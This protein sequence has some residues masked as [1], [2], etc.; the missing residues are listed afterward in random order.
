MIAIDTNIV[1]R[2][3]TKDDE[4]QYRVSWNLIKDYQVFIGDTVILE[5]EWVLRHAY[6]FSSSEISKAFKSLFGLKNVRMKDT[7]RI[8]EAI[9][10]YDLG[11]DFAD[12]LHFVIGEE[13]CTRF[14][15][16]DKKFCNKANE[17]SD[18]EVVCLSRCS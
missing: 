8:V 14:F 15:T 10:L 4:Y 11:L 1:V 5:T 13:D 7:G 2:F 9:R 3:L 16:F 12:A 18:F 6:G 17:F